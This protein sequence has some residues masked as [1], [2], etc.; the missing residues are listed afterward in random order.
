[1]QIYDRFPFTFRTRINMTRIKVKVK[2]GWPEQL[3]VEVRKDYDKREFLIPEIGCDFIS[4]K[5]LQADVA[6]VA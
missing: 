2:I 5:E 1:M 3:F 6:T 4:C